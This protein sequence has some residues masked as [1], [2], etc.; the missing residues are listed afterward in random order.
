[1]AT[2][3]LGGLSSRELEVLAAVE[4]RLNNIEIADELFISVRTVESHV[5]ALRRKL[6]IESRTELIE[7]AQRQRAAMIQ[8]P[9]NSF[10]GR[11][12]ELVEVRALLDRS[13]W[14]TIVGPPGC[15]KTRL[16][17]ELAAAGRSVPLL[18]EMEHATEADVVRTVAGT[19]GIVG[20]EATNLTAACAIALVAH[21]YLLVLD[22]CDRVTGAV[23]RL[24]ASLTA[25]ALSLTVLA[26]SRS[27]LGGT[28]ETVYQLAP[29]AVDG[30]NTDGAVRL[31]V[32]RATS[33]APGV[34]FSASD[35]TA[36]ERICLRLDGLP[37]AIELAA[38]R[39]RHLP[40][41]ELADRLDAGL[42]I[43]DGPGHRGR[44][45]TV[46]AAFDWTWDLL[47]DE[48]RLVLSRLAAL[49][50]T[51]D[52]E[53]ADAVTGGAAHVVLR[54]LDRSL[55]SQTLGA[56]EPR[57]FR[58]LNS[59]RSCVA[60]RSDPNVVRDARHA[61]ARYHAE[62]A[63]DLALRIRTDDRPESV[64]HAKRLGPEVAAAITWTCGADPTLALSLTRALSVLVEHSG[65]DLDSLSAIAHA[66]HTPT[67]I[68]AAATDALLEIGMAVSSTDLNLIATL[69]SRALEIMD[70]DASRLCAHQLA[71][72]AAAYRSPQSAFVHLDTAE[73]LA[74]E[75][76]DLWQLASVRQGKGIALRG[77]DLHDAPGAIAMFE[78]AEQTFALAGDAMHANNCRNMMAATAAM[79]GHR[80]D[81]AI[82]WAAQCVAYAKASGN[83]Q[84]LAHAM[85]SQAALNGGPDAL[86][87]LTETVDL[88]RSVGDCRCLT[89]S[90]LRLADLSAPEERIAFLEDALKTAVD[91]HDLAHQ[92]TALERLAAGQWD[93]GAHRRAAIA[94]GGLAN[95]VGLDAATSRCPTAMAAQLSAW[96]GA[97]AEG[98]GLGYRAH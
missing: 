14:V 76:H 97:I 54:L 9:M 79:A 74:T 55:V 33:A 65:P 11:A 47:D 43:L 1:M 31:F 71:G 96:A 7:A 5:A 30:A 25:R 59:I 84:E 57:R 73:R 29:L 52:M 93:L 91:A 86:D 82:T 75:L 21:R 12:R 89:R 34:R 68:D 26:T 35:L 41:G 28:D 60:G 94:L 49:P 51:F 24:I 77:D 23:A 36:V 39:V 62:Q 72:W 44:H 64:R 40:V 32:D 50:R 19:I 16:A 53:L 17:L 3:G 18:A 70:D 37:L 90:Y 6:G 87:A 66:A 63:A 67:V 38:A 85:F 15:G 45:V 2:D 56:T 78:S 88:F 95:L 69:A 27:P 92:A 46:E 81:E 48:E 4:R 13:R 61:H 80:T 22:D 10:V 83:V 8:V 20:G 42:E 98:R 58:L